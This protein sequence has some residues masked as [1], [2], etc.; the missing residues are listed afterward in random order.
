MLWSRMVMAVKIEGVDPSSRLCNN[1]MSQRWQPTRRTVLSP[2]TSRSLRYTAHSAAKPLRDSLLPFSLLAC[3]EPNK[4][5]VH[6]HRPVPLLPNNKVPQKD[7]LF[8]LSAASQPKS[9]LF[10]PPR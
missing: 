6:M 9:R 10:N 7:K 8:F 3:V 5:R 2:G 4:K 1:P